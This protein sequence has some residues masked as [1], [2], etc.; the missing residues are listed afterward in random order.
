MPKARYQPSKI[1]QLYRDT[2]TGIY[3][4]RADDAKGNDTWRS[5]STKSFEIA[6]ARL[7]GKIAEIQTGRVSQR[8]ND[9]TETLGQ[10]AEIY[11]S[12][13]QA[14][15]GLKP[16]SVHYRCQTLDAIFRS[17]PPLAKLSPSKVT[18]DACLQWAKTYQKKVHPTRFNNTV[19]TLRELFKLAGE[20]SLTNQN[21]A[22]KIGKL[23]VSPK[24]LNLPSRKQFHMIVE[25]IRNTGAWCAQDAADLV[26]FLAYSGCR[27]TEAS[28]V[29]W[30]DVNGKTGTI[31]IHGHEL[32]GTKN[33]ESRSIPFTAPMRDLLDRLSTRRQQ[34]RDPNRIGKGF[35]VHVTECQ[36]A[37]ENACEKVGA[38]R[39]THHDLRHLFATRCI[40][41]GVDIPTVSR[42]LGHKDGGALAMKTYGHLRDEHSQMMAAKVTF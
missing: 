19:G 29:R 4:A 13:V 24:K 8:T 23:K 32:T 14:A 30:A 27:I 36:K 7:A 17:W 15:V 11:R 25:A 10:I 21:P 16:A 26:E 31:R 22:L 18:E 39:L 28:C 6:K 1:S 37:L 5:L 40:E 12:R 33:S 41:A 20:L 35:I 9:S 38:K 2:K 34:P 3:Y 42:W